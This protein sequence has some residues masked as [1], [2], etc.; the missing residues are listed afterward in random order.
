MSSEVIYLG[1]EGH[2][3]PSTAVS[4]HAARCVPGPGASPRGFCHWPLPQSHPRFLSDHKTL[5]KSL[6][7]SEPRSPQR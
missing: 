3:Q 5:A 6:N 2:A 1:L 4:L 7:A